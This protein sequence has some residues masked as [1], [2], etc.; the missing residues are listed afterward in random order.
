MF[1]LLMPLNPGKENGYQPRFPAKPEARIR[2]EGWRFFAGTAPDLACQA[3]DITLW[4]QKAIMPRAMGKGRKGVPEEKR[5]ALQVV[6]LPLCP[7]S[8]SRRRG[9][10]PGNVC[11]C[12]CVAPAR[13]RK[14][15]TG[16][17]RLPTSLR[18]KSAVHGD[19]YLATPIGYGRT[20]RAADFSRR[21]TRCGSFHAPSGWEMTLLF[22]FHSDNSLI[23]T[24]QTLSR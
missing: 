19:L 8:E 4:Q 12:T 10:H 16:R 15:Q 9:A 21:P 24:A 20:P 13:V 23:Q 14:L 5:R 6:H 11:A 3:L 1:R 18:E 7:V 22:V 2:P 17:Q